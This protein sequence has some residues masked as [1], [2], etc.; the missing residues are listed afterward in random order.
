MFMYT[1][2]TN[3]GGRRCMMRL[4]ERMMLSFCTA[5]GASTANAWTLLTEAGEDVRVMTRKS[6]DDPGRPSG[7]VLSASTSFWLPIP[8]RTVFDFLRSENSRNQVMYKNSSVTSYI[9]YL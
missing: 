7:I 1:V 4:A 3:S 6:V 2:L 9:T 5:V 8:S